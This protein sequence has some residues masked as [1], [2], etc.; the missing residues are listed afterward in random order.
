MASHALIW[1]LNL[2]NLAF[3]SFTRGL[4]AD[5]A[6]A[7]IEIR[8]VSVACM[9]PVVAMCGR[10]KAIKRSWRGVVG[11]TRRGVAL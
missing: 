10:G 7:G 8:D 1:R 4:S 3:N 9:L 5:P 6:N 2:T 11:V